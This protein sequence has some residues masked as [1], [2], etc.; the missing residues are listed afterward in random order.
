MNSAI[1]GAEKEESLTVPLRAAHDCRFRGV[2]GVRGPEHLHDHFEHQLLHTQTQAFSAQRRFCK[3]R[4]DCTSAMLAASRFNLGHTHSGMH[5]IYAAKSAV[6]CY[7]L[8]GP[9]NYP[10]DPLV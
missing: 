2:G 10:L 8:A 7:Q 3:A 9:V 4:I 5:I 1:V 6:A